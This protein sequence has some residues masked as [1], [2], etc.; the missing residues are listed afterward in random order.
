M[1]TSSDLSRLLA[2]A[3]LAATF[4]ATPLA[5]AQ[6]GTI[7]YRAVLNG[8]NEAPPIESK[9]TGLAT[10]VYDDVARTLLV[11][12]T[13]QDLTGTTTAAHIHA[14]TSVAGTGTA[15]VAT[16]TP[17]FPGFPA[18]V[19]SGTYSNLFDLTQ[20]SSWNAAYVT[21]YGGTTAGAEVALAAAMANGQAYFNIH[22]S[23]ARGG[24]IRGFLQRVPEPGSS[25]VLL[26]IGVAGL[27]ARRQRRR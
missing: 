24:E 14:A 11:S 6:A 3:L 20:A 23:F 27:A 10:V 1:R 21:A 25:I 7:T 5:T 18:G 19:T 8:P 22:T 9:G 2:V 17:T 12:A 13:F 4:A 26:G 16:T 15:G